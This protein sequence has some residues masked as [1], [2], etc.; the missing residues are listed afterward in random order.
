MNTCLQ[1]ASSSHDVQG[2]SAKQ[3]PVTSDS[4]TVPLN[5]TVGNLVDGGYSSPYK[6]R[7]AGE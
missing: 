1:T 6:N 4:L 7:V 2:M 3:P 5:D